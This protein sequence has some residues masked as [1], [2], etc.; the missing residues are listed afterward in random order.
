M[1]NTSWVTNIKFHSD[2]KILRCCLNT[3]TI[4]KTLQKYQ[5]NS[6]KFDK[7]ESK[8]FKTE[9]HNGTL[10]GI[11]KQTTSP[12]NKIGRIN[13]YT[14]KIIKHHK[15][16]TTHNKPTHISGHVRT[17]LEI[18]KTNEHFRHPKNTLTTH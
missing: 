16:K 12:T 1:I 13:K 9:Y 2:H 14:E 3:K 11:L 4:S 10:K 18:P 15:L 6:V 8:I 5:V 17:I 7:N